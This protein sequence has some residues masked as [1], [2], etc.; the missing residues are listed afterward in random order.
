MISIVTTSRLLDSTIKPKMIS[1]IH[2]FIQKTI[3][4]SQNKTL[5]KISFTITDNN[6][7]NGTFVNNVKIGETLLLKYVIL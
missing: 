7:K 1:K 6:T 2:C 5:R 4:N 3:E